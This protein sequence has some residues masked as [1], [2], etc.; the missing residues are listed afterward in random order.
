MDTVCC[1]SLQV[2]LRRQRTGPLELPRRQRPA[3]RG[4]QRPVRLA[5]SPLSRPLQLLLLID[6][7]PLR[8]PSHSHRSGKQRVDVFLLYGSSSYDE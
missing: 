4:G 5:L 6:R 2:E 7:F 3:P 1:L 8:H